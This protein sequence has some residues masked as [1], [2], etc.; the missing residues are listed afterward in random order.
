[1]GALGKAKVSVVARGAVL[2]DPPMPFQHDP[3]IT[4]QVVNSVG[5]CWG[6]DYVTPPQ[7]NASTRLVA[8]ERP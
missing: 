3:T 8:R 4:I 7:V 6:V 2:P 1:M 5:S